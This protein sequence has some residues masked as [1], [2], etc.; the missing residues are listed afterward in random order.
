M[1]TAVHHFSAAHMAPLGSFGGRLM[2][3]TLV[4]HCLLVEG[5]DGLTLVDTGFGTAD[6]A[7]RRMGTAFRLAARVGL[8]RS[9]TALAHVE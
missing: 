1:V 6:L 7:Q 2:P 3:S 4:A 5:A 9:N 8:D